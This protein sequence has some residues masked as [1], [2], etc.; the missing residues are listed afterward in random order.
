MIELYE[1]QLKNFERQSSKGNQLKWQNDNYW[2]KADY[3]GY[4][5]LVEYVVSKLLSKSNLKPVEYVDYELEKIKYKRNTFYGVR[6]EGFLSDTALDYPMNDDVVDMID[7]VKS[8]TI[9]TDFDMQLDSV[10]KIFGYNIKFS[11]S[12]RLLR[13]Y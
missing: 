8:K 5:G 11:F 1:N 9:C 7:E 12:K 13:L 3:A 10:E 4:E 2:Y 6:S